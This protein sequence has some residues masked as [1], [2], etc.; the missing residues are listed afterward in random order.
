MPLSSNPTKREL[1]LIKSAIRKNCIECSHDY[2]S[3]ESG[4]ILW[5]WSPFN[6][7]KAK[8]KDESIINRV[9]NLHEEQS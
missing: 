1:S 3:A 5:K 2:C 8:P 7:G 4:C 6:T 9:E